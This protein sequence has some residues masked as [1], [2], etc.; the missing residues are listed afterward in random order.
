MAWSSF[1]KGRRLAKSLKIMLAISEVDG[2][3]KT[4]GLAD[5]GR[6]L[7]LALKQRG[8]DVRVVLPFYK[9]IPAG[10]FTTALETL[11]V[12]MGNTKI[13]CAVRQ[14]WMGEVPL[15]L[16][17][18]DDFFARTSPYDDGTFPYADN[19]ERFGFFS[20]AVFHTCQ[21]LQF[22]PDIL[23]CNDWQ[24]ALVPFYLKVHE[25]AHPFFQK[26]ASVLTLHNASFQGKFPATASVFLGIGWEHF[27][28]QQF[29]DF[30]QLNF[31]KGGLAW[32]DKIN[33]VSPGYAQELL[34]PLGGHGLHE[35]FLNRQNDLQGILNGCESS[36]W[37]PATD[38][39]LPAHYHRMDFSGKALCKK[40]LQH[41][42][43]LNQA[44][45]IPLIG[46][47]TRITTQ[48]GFDYLLPALQTLLQE[49]VQLVILGTGEPWIEEALRHLAERFPENF[50][51]RNEYHEELSHWIEA[52][53]DLFLMPS[54]FEPCGLNQMYSLRYGTLPIVRAVGGL[55]DTVRP[56]D[57]PKG[58]GFLFDPP[59]PQALLACVQE[60][61]TVYEKHPKMF[62]RL[63]QNAMKATFD[64]EVTARHYEK[65]YQSALKK[66]KQDKSGLF[67]E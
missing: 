55:K 19:A 41:R 18:Y 58:T 64:W 5:V 20:K 2:F 16:V 1:P 21:A 37:N 43:G 22:V 63:V 12:S 42:L 14:G 59:T 62:Q 47:V 45:K 28:A 25:A 56:H 51:W 4:G 27:T 66:Q 15:Y 11:Q 7:P 60:A 65:L 23:H 44:A 30:G 52:G 3:V 10:S 57:Q 36:H 48:K 26:T 67:R 49:N 35:L 33:A 24:T 38:P 61:L 17:E 39:F 54:L 46:M 34:T 6:A 53:A 40:A 13:W 50:R 32:A 29:E 9:S 8:H 31:L